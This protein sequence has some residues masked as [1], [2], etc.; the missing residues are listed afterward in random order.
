[1]YYW[2]NLFQKQYSAVIRDYPFHLWYFEEKEGRK[3][4]NQNFFT[5]NLGEAQIA[6][7]KFNK[8]RDTIRV[9]QLLK[10]ESCKFLSIIRANNT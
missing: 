2:Q 10:G 1:M 7:N 5:G 4:G 8:Y 9:F 3:E 6:L